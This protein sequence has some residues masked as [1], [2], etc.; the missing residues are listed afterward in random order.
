MTNGFQH[1]S[2]LTLRVH[3]VDLTY[4]SAAIFFE[5]S[6]WV[7]V[8]NGQKTLG[9]LK[10]GRHTPHHPHPHFRQTSDGSL[11]LQLHAEECTNDQTLKWMDSEWRG[12]TKY[13]RVCHTV[14]AFVFP[15]SAIFITQ[16]WLQASTVTKFRKGCAR[17]PTMISSKQIKSVH[18][19]IGHLML[20]TMTQAVMSRLIY[21]KHLKM[22]LWSIQYHHCPFDHTGSF[23]QMHLYFKKCLYSQIIMFSFQS[24]ASPFQCSDD[25][26]APR[27]TVA[28][29]TCSL[30]SLCCF[31]TVH[32]SIP[33]YCV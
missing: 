25:A 27:N 33:Y 10:L 5:L 23:Q 3:F 1:F 7:K 30:T 32:C 28:V 8:W 6:I 16:K 2:I 26:C 14:Q 17:S 29:A 21:L 31:F 4:E 11:I 15:Q 19:F 9:N 24:S 18:C 22:I 20:N 13:T 12:E